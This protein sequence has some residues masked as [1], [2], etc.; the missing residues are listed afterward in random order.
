[1]IS[2]INEWELA[3]KHERALKS[4]DFETCSIIKKEIERRIK[5]KTINHAFMSGFQYWDPK[6]ESFEG[7]PKYGDV[8]GLFDNYKQSK[9]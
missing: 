1:M 5:D 6:T 9:T 2:K 3:I 7:E 4:E 8:N